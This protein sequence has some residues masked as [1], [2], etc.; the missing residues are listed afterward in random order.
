M[1]LRD[2]LVYCCINDSRV[3]RVPISGWIIHEKIWHVCNRRF[4]IDLGKKA[5][6]WK[7]DKIRCNAKLFSSLIMQRL[8]SSKFLWFFFRSFILHFDILLDL[9]LGNFHT[10]ELTCMTITIFTLEKKSLALYMW[11]SYECTFFSSVKKI[12]IYTYTW[13]IITQYRG[14]NNKFPKYFLHRVLDVTGMMSLHFFL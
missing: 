6:K 9:V 8:F 2:L 3:G 12:Y 4:H 7:R 5:L 14:G 13:Y 11:K 10:T 1:R